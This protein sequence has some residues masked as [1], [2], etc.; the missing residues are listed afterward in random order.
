MESEKNSE[1]GQES[2]PNTS[3]NNDSNSNQKQINVN[4]KKNGKKKIDYVFQFGC[5]KSEN[6]YRN[7]VKSDGKEF[8]EIE[9]VRAGDRRLPSH[10]VVMVNGIMGSAEN[11]RFAAK[12]FLKR[13][14]EDFL[15]HCSKCNSSSMTFDGVDI[16]GERLADEVI[17][18]IKRRPELQKISF[19][20]HSLGGL[21]AR[22]AIGRL[23]EQ[24]PMHEPSDRNG[25]CRGDGSGNA[26]LE[27]KSKGKIAGL[28][29]M[30]FITI[31]TPHLGSR[32]H[33]QVP[34]FCG[35]HF[36][37]KTAK[38][39]SWLLG[40]TG[41]HLFLTD[42]DNGKPPL[43]LQMVND[44]GDLQFM[45]ALQS[46]KR[47]VTYSN[48]CFDHLVGWRASSIRRHNELP[49]REQ[50]LKNEKYPHI[51]YVEP[52][53]IVSSQQEVLTEAKA[54]A[55]KSSEME[56]AMIRGLTKVSWERVDVSFHRSKQ[57]FLAHTTI[58]ASFSIFLEF[59]YIYQ[60]TFGA[61][62]FSTVEILLLTFYF[63]TFLCF[64]SGSKERVL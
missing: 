15:V 28:E 37:E 34:V 12:Q 24:N 54:N 47:R 31:A 63:N 18:V 56:E 60:R 45:S 46:F 26:C 59:N 23:Y 30:N 36:L 16:M 6:D 48:A 27:K 13:Y 21:V 11:W 8:L 3:S 53:K 43:L 32:G 1:T 61:P 19:V 33:K 5:F 49:K 51:V 57:R 44:C 20:A 64:I 17:S 25:D 50:F 10:L 4:K 7:P 62:E 55:L 40:R 2:E 22:Y 41:K 38:N 9:S 58:Q 14:P 35:L 39:T 29:P 52:P 42:G